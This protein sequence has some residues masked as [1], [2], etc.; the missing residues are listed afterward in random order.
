MGV[1]NKEPTYVHIFGQ[2][3]ISFPSGD[4]FWAFQSCVHGCIFWSEQFGVFKPSGATDSNNCLTGS[5]RSEIGDAAR[6]EG[7]SG[8]NWR[9]CSGETGLEETCGGRSLVTA[10]AVWR[11]QHL[12]PAGR[13]KNPYLHR[14]SA[15]HHTLSSLLISNSR[16]LE[17]IATAHNY[18]PQKS[19][20]QLEYHPN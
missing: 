13:L 4:G 17:G 10:P 15:D 9:D 2:R 5:G 8:D 1:E 20:S 12:E 3:T 14:I 7:G 11:G 18:E 6:C 16:S 19:L